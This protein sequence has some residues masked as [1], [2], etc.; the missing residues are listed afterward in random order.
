MQLN[1][2]ENPAAA[3][4]IAPPLKG[5]TLQQEDFILLSALFSRSAE[6]RH[7]EEKPADLKHVPNS[8]SQSERF[9]AKFLQAH[10]AL[11]N[12]GEC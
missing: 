11:R 12:L 1:R 10:K 3:R 5:N 8:L 9:T 6:E 2:S 7:A 4:V